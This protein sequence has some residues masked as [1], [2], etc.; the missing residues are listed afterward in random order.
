M[1]KRLDEDGVGKKTRDSI[2]GGRGRVT[3]KS[4]LEHLLRE[5]A[6][7]G[8]S[9]TVEKEVHSILAII[10]HKERLTVLIT[11]SVAQLGTLSKREKQ[12]VKLALEEKTKKEIAKE[13]HITPNTVAAHFQRIYKKLGIARRVGFAM[14][15]PA[16]WDPDA[17]GCGVGT[18]AGNS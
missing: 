3:W 5:A 10:K 7:S 15:A 14:Y 12:I 13:L 4:L 16:F 18:G 11:Y 17:F 1:I 2:T 9:G 8:L 6:T